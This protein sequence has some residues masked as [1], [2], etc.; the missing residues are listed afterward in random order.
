MTWF[1][2]CL[3]AVVLGAAAAVAACGSSDKGPSAPRPIGTNECRAEGT[4]CPTGCL[5]VL[6]T[7]VDNVNRCNQ[8]EFVTCAITKKSLMASACFVRKSTGQVFVSIDWALQEPEFN[9]Y[10][11]CTADEKTRH[12][13]ISWSLN[14]CDKPADAG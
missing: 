3:Q 14:P 10:R 6:A 7:R 5:P 9:D 13:P 2:V 4:T 1:R 12:N 8:Y 11:L